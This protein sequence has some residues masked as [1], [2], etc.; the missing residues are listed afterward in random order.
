[1]INYG[2]GGC[3]QTFRS[4]NSIA[5]CDQ[6]AAFLCAGGDNLHSVSFF[7]QNLENAIGFPQ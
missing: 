2:T 3:W 6:P 1:M 4:S 7:L 5:T